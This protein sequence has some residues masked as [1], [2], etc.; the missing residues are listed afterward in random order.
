MDRD[1]FKKSLEASG[2]TP[3]LVNAFLEAYDKGYEAGVEHV[4]DQ[5]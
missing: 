1:E 5:L 4:T 2:T 3:A